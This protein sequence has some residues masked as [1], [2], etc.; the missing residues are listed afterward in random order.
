[1]GRINHKLEPQTDATRSMAAQSRP[2]LPAIA[3]DMPFQPSA[4]AMNTN[5]KL[6]TSPG[7]RTNDSKGV[8]QHLLLSRAR[9]PIRIAIID[10]H[11][12]VTLGITTYLRS[13]PEFLVVHTETSAQQLVDHLKQH[14]CDAAVV[15]F[16]LPQQPWDGVNFIRRLRRQHPNMAIISF[17]A[18]KP[19]ETEYAAFRAGASGYLPKLAALTALADM[20]HT[21]VL[22]PKLFVAYRDGQIQQLNPVPPETRLT[23]AEVEILRHIAQ[24]LS[25]T[26][27]AARLLRSKKTVST[28]KRRAMRKLGLANDLALALYLKEK[29]EQN[30]SA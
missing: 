15:D 17:S 14:P 6:H 28:H 5:F 1:M 20:I 12:A 11:P 27:V 9:Q 10:D 25:V 29:F 8:Q 23:N 16:Y 7:G 18:G 13:K 30:I 22:A 2:Y 19:A 24:G 21:A 3:A 4:D 26:Q